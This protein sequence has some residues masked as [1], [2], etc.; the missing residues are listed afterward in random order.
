MAATFGWR[1]PQA[2]LKNQLHGPAGQPS[3]CQA[4]M[5][6]SPHAFLMGTLGR[7]W[8]YIPKAR[9]KSC[10]RNMQRVWAV[11]A[12]VFLVASVAIATFGSESLSLGQALF[13]IDHDLADKVIGS[14]KRVVGN[15]AWDSLVQPLMQRPDWLIPACFGII[16]LGLSLSLT[17]RKSAR[18]SHRR[19]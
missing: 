16:S 9:L 1:C 17:G 14:T 6:E 10:I 19:S 13:Q 2:R 4:P 12:A 7:L 8:T 11:I 3:A 15:W 5:K 18:Q